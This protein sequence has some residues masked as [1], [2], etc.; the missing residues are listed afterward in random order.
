MTGRPTR[1]CSANAATPSSRPGH[2]YLIRSAE[3]EL[4]KLWLDTFA[5]SGSA[6]WG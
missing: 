2:A 4:D 3:A 5:D 1:F 6:S